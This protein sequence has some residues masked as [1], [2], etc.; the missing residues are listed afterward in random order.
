MRDRAAAGQRHVRVGYNHRFHPSLAKLAAA[1]RSGELRA[2]AVRAGPVRARRAARLRAGVAGRA[3]RGRAAGSSSTRART[4]STW[5]GRC[6]GD[7]DLAFAELPT[8]FWPMDVEDNAFL[9]LRPRSGGFAWLHASWTEWK[10]LFSFEVM[11]ERAKLEVTGLGGSYG[12]ERLTVLRDG[13]ASWARRRRP[14]TSG[15]P[16]T[17]S[18]RLR[19]RRRR[20]GHPGRAAIGCLA[21]RRHRR[22]RPDRGGLRPMIISRTPLRISLGGGGTDLPVV[23]PPGGP[24]LPHRRRHHEVRVHRRPPQLRRRRAAQVLLASS[25]CRRPSDAA[26][27]LLRCCLADDRRGPRR[28]GD[29]DG[30]HP[31][32]HRPRLVRLVH[33]RRPQGAARLPARARVERR[34]RRRG[35]PHRD[36][37][38]R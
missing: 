21:R 1:V 27:P 33:R 3:G 30:R 25:G 31:D 34:P 5:S 14:R 28:R 7:V 16:A 19:A 38:L 6:F 29:L 11:L 22:A 9:A 10:N 23:L 4:S 37:P 36:R 20:R 18:W 35:V 24:R 32:R 8:A 17:D 26:H 2:A 15:R 13:P 12:P